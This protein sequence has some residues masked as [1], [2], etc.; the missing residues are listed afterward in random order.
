MLY[1]ICAAATFTACS[2]HLVVKSD[3]QYFFHN[4][5][6]VDRAVMHIIFV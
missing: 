5:N 3:L 2:V 4:N 6:Q 1:H